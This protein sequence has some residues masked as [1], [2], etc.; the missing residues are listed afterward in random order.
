M[1]ALWATIRGQNLE[2]IFLSETKASECRIN[3]VASLLILLNFVCVESLGRSGGICMFWTNVMQVEVLEFDSN[4]IAINLIDSVCNWNMV[5]FYGPPHRSNRKIVGKISLLCLIPL[6]NRGFE[7]FE[8]EGGSIGCSSM[9]NYLK[10]LLFELGA[11]DLG[12]AGISLLGVKRDGVKG[13]SEK[14]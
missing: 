9:P 11:I 13:V 7:D 14:G 8:K 6:R 4:L 2:V 10:N 1:K 5:G 3:K 12:F